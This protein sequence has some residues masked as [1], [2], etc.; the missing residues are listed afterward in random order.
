M[1]KPQPQ[2]S[3]RKPQI[4]DILK[5]CILLYGYNFELQQKIQSSIDP[6]SDGVNEKCCIIN[7]E[8]I[9]KFKDIYKYKLIRKNSLV[10]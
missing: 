8:W 9:K 5:K 2:D 1:S 7:S 3:I 4:D 6:L 10:I